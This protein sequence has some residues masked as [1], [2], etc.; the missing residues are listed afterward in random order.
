[1]V[2]RNNLVRK[3]RKSLILSRHAIQHSQI[4]CPIIV[5]GALKYATCTS[6]GYCD[7]I[8]TTVIQ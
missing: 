7:T 1:M 5:K 6:E 8:V 3:K 2:Q 4:W